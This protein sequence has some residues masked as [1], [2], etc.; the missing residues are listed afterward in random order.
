MQVRQ[1][2][3]WGPLLQCCKA[4]TCTCLSLGY[5]IQRNYRK[6]KLTPCTQLRQILEQKIQRHFWRA[7]YKIWVL[8]MSPL[9]TILPKGLENQ[10]SH[11][12]SQ[13]SL[14]EFLVWPLANFYW[15]EK[16]KNHGCYHKYWIKSYFTV[17]SVTSVSFLGVTDCK[18]QLYWNFSWLRDSRSSYTFPTK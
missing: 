16:A 18:V 5:K 11:P 14:P 10:L 2:G 7:G 9:H 12:S 4:C 8:G 1:A 3:T 13:K 15:L 17:P 6:L